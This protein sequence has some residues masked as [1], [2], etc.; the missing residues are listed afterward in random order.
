M[1]LH[2]VAVSDSGG[3]PKEHKINGKDHGGAIEFTN[4]EDARNRLRTPLRDMAGVSNA[5]VIARSVEGRLDGAIDWPSQ[6]DVRGF[7]TSRG[8]MSMD[9]VKFV[10]YGD[11]QEK[12]AFEPCG[13]CKDFEG[14]WHTYTANLTFSQEGCGLVACACCCARSCHVCP[15][16][17]APAGHRSSSVGLRRQPKLVKWLWPYEGIYLDVD[18]TLINADNLGAHN[19]PAE[20][21]DSTAGV[22][23]HADFDSLVSRPGECTPLRASAGSEPDAA[24]GALCRATVRFRRVE[25]TGLAPSSIKYQLLQIT[26]L[27]N[28]ESEDEEPFRTATADFVKGIQGYSVTLPTGR[29]YWLHT[30]L[31]QRV[32]PSQLAVSKSEAMDAED[33]LLLQTKSTRVRSSRPCLRGRGRCPSGLRHAASAIWSGW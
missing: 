6:R 32:D 19:L 25:V 9:T 28:A 1:R 5:L 2:N 18:G 8:T 29:E 23:W 10:G 24:L 31:P 15:A 7:I 27:S 21:G 33:Y 3:G 20:W 17:C 26:D 14:G 4:V 13:K 16:C 11:G 22:T 30:K 12:L